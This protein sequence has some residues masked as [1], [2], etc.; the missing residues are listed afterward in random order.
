VGRREVPA[1]RPPLERGQVEG[2]VRAA[3]V[4]PSRRSSGRGWPQSTSRLS[5]TRRSWRTPGTT[6]RLV[7]RVSRLRSPPLPLA[8]SQR[9]AAEH[10]QLASPFAVEQ[11]EWGQPTRTP[12]PPLVALR[13]VGDAPR[14]GAR[15][16]LRPPP[17]R[18][19]QVRR[20][21]GP[22][23]AMVSTVRVAPLPPPAC[24]RPRRRALR[25]A[26]M[27]DAYLRLLHQQAASTLRGARRRAVGTTGVDVR[28]HLT[29]SHWAAWA[30]AR[31]ARTARRV[32]PRPRRRR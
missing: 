8:L 15:R 21:P 5:V 10:G 3:E 18:R 26:S 22:L 4:V 11:R 31:Q 14:A 24:P 17:N 9:A 16:R 23:D 27:V 13:A 1:P 25:Q 29:P 12:P 20:T 28:R 2:H 7:R 6:D 30:S 32:S 19:H